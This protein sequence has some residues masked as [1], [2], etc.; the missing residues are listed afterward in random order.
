MSTFD[1]DWGYQK[2]FT[3]TDLILIAGVTL[4]VG[5]LTMVVR[6]SVRRHAPIPVPPP[7]P[8]ERFYSR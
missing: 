2:R 5:V 1:H 4:A 3:P 8:I 6:F 7:T